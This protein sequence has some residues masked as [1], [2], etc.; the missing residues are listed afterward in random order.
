MEIGAITSHI[1]VA[2]V[3]LYVFWAF[4]FGLVFYLRREDRREGYPLETH[5]GEQ[6][7]PGLIWVPAPK[8]FKLADGRTVYAPNDRQE[9]RK[10]NAEQITP[11]SGSPWVP[12]GDPMKDGVGP[13]AWAEREDIP[14]V[15]ID[16][17]P[18]IVPMRSTSEVAIAEGDPDPRGMPVLDADRNIAG[19]V[20]DIWVD[21][22]EHMI[23]Y[24]EVETDGGRCLLP[25]TFA[26]VDRRRKQV[27]VESILAEQFSSVP[28]TK[29]PDQV[30]RLEEDQIAAYY[31]SGHL[32]ATPDRQ[33]PLI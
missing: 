20:A 7:D 8:S 6:V 4:F 28:Q 33:E 19:T 10:I 16:G 2:Q 21:H 12:K 22:S 5:S 3:V 23:R 29:N 27:T 31:G 14:D 32:Y 18:R 25:M 26:L 1:D 17:H 13:A 9:T 11:V 24:L 15:T 30:T